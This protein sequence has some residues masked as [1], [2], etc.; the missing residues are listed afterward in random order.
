MSRFSIP[1]WVKEISFT[2]ENFRDLPES[3]LTD[4]KTGLSRFRVSD[5]EVSI[6]IPAW[7]EERNL[8][9][10]LA[11]LSKLKL[12]FKTELIIINNNSTDRTQE[13]ID[14]FGVKTFFQP[15]QGISVTRQLGLE[16]AKG[17]YILSADADSLYPPNWGIDYV[18]ELKKPNISVVYGRY[19]FIPSNGARFPLAIHEILAETIF[20][21]RRQKKDC[22]NVMGFNS[23]F[24][25]QEAI[26]IGG[27]SK[28]NM[29]WEDGMLAKKISQKFGQIS[30]VETSDSRPWTSDRR[31]MADGSLFKAFVRRVKKELSYIHQL[32]PLLNWQMEK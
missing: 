19:S 5:P 26:A 23:A 14:F 10:T 6:V 28:T 3:I 1:N 20:K 24:K 7:N 27:Y 22:V 25:R 30:L 21:L 15:I 18:N 12:P 9:N 4:I 29:R 17:K 16:N 32:I 11:S 31:L 13:I 8:V 2:Y